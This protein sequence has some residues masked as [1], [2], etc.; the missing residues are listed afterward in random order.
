M[1]SRLI[2]DTS[3]E[4]SLIGIEAWNIG[5]NI[6]LAKW[7]TIEQIPYC[8]INNNGVTS[9][10]YEDKDYSWFYNEIC[11]AITKENFLKELEEDF[12]E[13]AREAKRIIEKSS[14]SKEDILALYEILIKCWPITT[15]T[16]EA[17]TS[18]KISPDSQNIQKI[19]NMRKLYG[20]ALYEIEDSIIDIISKV[21]PQLNGYA[22]V[23]SIKEIE[24]ESLPP[25]KILEKRKQHY[26]FFN[27]DLIENRTLSEF[28]NENNL[29]MPL[30]SEKI[31]IEGRVAMQGMV[32]GKVKK[33]FTEKDV[34][35]VN[36]GDI[37]VAPMTTPDHVIAMEKAAA[38]VTDEGGITCH[39]AIIAREF[40]KPCIV[41]TENATKIL[42]DNDLVLVDAYRGIVEKIYR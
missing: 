9:L 2:K 29:E 39:A 10:Y 36:V 23:V 32:I 26:I 24:N 16:Y 35:K 27:G 28:L 15:I 37:I 7:I 21:Y 18:R 40:K 31:K 34:E 20:A 33:I 17:T 8:F 38:F 19:F 5:E 22:S 41:G 4:N 3:R 30:D 25:H 1:K 12:L 6:E 14:H 11:Q 42:N 13:N